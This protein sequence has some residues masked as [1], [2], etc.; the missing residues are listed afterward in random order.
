MKRI[1]LALTLLLTLVACKAMVNEMKTVN[2]I[3]KIAKEHCECKFVSV[4]KSYDA[5]NSIMTLTL[6][7]SWSTDHLLTAQNVYQALQ[8]SM[9]KICNYGKV[10]IIFEGDEF[11]E[12]IVFYG[13]DIEPEIDTVF[14][15]EGGYTD[16][17]W[18][19]F[20]NDSVT[21]DGN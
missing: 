1:L 3:R 18:E 17:E 19:N 8:D 6:S 21:A 5:G 2:K 20:M 7:K 11:D 14:F 4:D 12:Y 16:E 10:S 15:E 9:P 13:C